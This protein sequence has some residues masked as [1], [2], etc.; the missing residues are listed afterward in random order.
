MTS[1]NSGVYLC[2]NVNIHTFR[3]IPLGSLGMVHNETLK[4]VAILNP[5]TPTD[6]SERAA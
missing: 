4:A 5:A 1:S 2:R 6:G 3:L